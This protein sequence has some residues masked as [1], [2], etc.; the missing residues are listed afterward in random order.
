MG[1]WE[2]KKKYKPITFSEKSCCPLKIVYKK[3]LAPPKYDCGKMLLPPFFVGKK[4]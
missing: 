2:Y 1:N 3:V 4:E